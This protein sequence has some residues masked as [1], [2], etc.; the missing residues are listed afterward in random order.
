MEA[1]FPKVLCPIDFSQVSIPAIELVRRLAL[2][3]EARIFLLYVLPPAEDDQT[4]DDLERIASDELPGVARKCLGVCPRN[5]H[6][7][8]EEKGQV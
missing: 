7:M 4:G 2:Q 5:S 8:L 3:N 1:Q 6:L